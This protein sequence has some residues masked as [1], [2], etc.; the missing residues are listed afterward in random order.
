M[1]PTPV[2]FDSPCRI[3]AIECG[4]FHS[5][6]RTVQGDVYTWGGNVPLATGHKRHANKPKMLQL[7]LEGSS[8]P[9]RAIQMVGGSQN[10]LFLVVEQPQRTRFPN[11]LL[12][13]LKAHPMDDRDAYLGLV[14]RLR[15]SLGPNPPD[16]LPKFGGNVGLANIHRVRSVAAAAGNDP[17]LIGV[18]EENAMLESREPNGNQPLGAVAAGNV[19]RPDDAVDE[20]YVVVEPQDPNGPPGVAAARW[21]PHP[22]D[23]GDEETFPP[24]AVHLNDS[25]SDPFNSLPASGAVAAVSVFNDENSANAAPIR[26]QPGKD[27]RSMASQGA[28]PDGS[29]CT[30]GGDAGSCN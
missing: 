30:D 2:L 1:T 21:A 17:L 20:E 9:L 3:A 18:G 22:D 28:I 5:M 16:C 27:S 8:T 29:D 23:E 24:V 26:Q 11:D 10:T 6:A 4:Y 13:A 25:I 7:R 19:P 15:E 14:Q 12:T